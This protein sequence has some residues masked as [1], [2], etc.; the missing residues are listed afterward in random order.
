MTLRKLL[1]T[2]LQPAIPSE[3][4]VI[5]LLCYWKIGV[6]WGRQG[7]MTV[8]LYTLEVGKIFSASWPAKP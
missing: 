5:I 4:I 2:C 1:D 7:R 3:L 6:A 8:S